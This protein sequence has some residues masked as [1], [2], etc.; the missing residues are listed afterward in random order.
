[1]ILTVDPGQAGERH[2]A[3][4]CALLWSSDADPR[5]LAA[6][7]FRS[8]H[9]FKAWLIRQ[10]GQWL[11]ADIIVRWTPAL[12]ASIPLASVITE[13]LFGEAARGA[14]AT[15]PEGYANV[16]LKRPV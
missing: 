5:L 14:A 13:V 2:E 4:I 8:V 7:H 10:R 3:R 16:P 6:E 15:P 11:G 12:A 9:E 1:V